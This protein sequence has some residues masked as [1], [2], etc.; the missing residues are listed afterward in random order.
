M[1]VLGEFQQE[2]GKLIFL[3]RELEIPQRELQSEE[4]AQLPQRMAS[5][6]NA[7]ANETFAGG[8]VSASIEFA[9]VKEQTGCELI[10]F[11]NPNT[12][13]MVTAGIGGALFGMF[14]VR[15]FDGQKWTY[16]RLVGDRAN[17]KPRQKYAVTV[18]V[19]GSRVAV[20]VDG[21]DVTAVD[22]PFALPASQ[23]GV[24]CMS[25]TKI[26]INNFKVETRKPVAF[27]VM[28]FTTPYN[29]LY[30]E[31]IRPICSRFGLEPFRADEEFVPGMIIAD[32]T[33]RL[34]EATVVVADITPANPNV[35]Y[36]VGYA[37]ALNKPTI[38]IAERPAQL[39]FDVSGF[40]TL[41]YD[42][43]IHGK[44]KV[45]EGLMS[46]L[47]AILAIT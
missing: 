9:D 16:H 23:V 35:Y 11:Y 37:H 40:R 10:L 41:F 5:I 38:L 33:R 22:L 47:K 14:S 36:E 15:H 46:H 44:A 18:S 30:A 1:P 24:W 19:A 42:N 34:V 27:I 29:E 12:R 39:P 6:G 31:V 4:T 7:L 25:H 17:L 32:V 13:F 21:V 3:G 20:S 2:K 28:Q 43:T 8:T 45:E 26:T